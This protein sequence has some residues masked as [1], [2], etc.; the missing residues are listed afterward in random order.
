[1]NVYRVHIKRFE[2]SRE[3]Q[4]W[5]QVYEVPKE[6]NLR[7]LDLLNYIYENIDP[8]LAYRRQLC[9]DGLCRS[10]EMTLNGRRV[11]ACLA[12]VTKLDEVR[13]E[14]AA[15]YPKIRDLIVDFGT[16]VDPVEIR[17]RTVGVEP[18]NKEG[19]GEQQ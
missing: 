13:I 10:C 17:Q 9:R 7:V 4:E 6:G 19:E 18:S 12:S 16:E 1:M 2:S 11:L 15:G 3:P 5:E 14:A 8:T